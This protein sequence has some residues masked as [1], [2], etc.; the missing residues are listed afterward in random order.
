M[1][2]I[3]KNRESKAQISDLS[4]GIAGLLL[5]VSLA[6]APAPAW[7]AYAAGPAGTAE[8]QANKSGAKH[9]DDDYVIGPSDV[10]AINVWKDTELSRTVLVRPDGRISLPLIGE[11]EV[12]GLTA[13]KVQELIA[14]KLGPYISKPQV[15]VIVTEVKS[16]TYTVV[17]KIAHPGSFEFGKPTTILDAIAIAGGFLDFARTNK[18]YVIRRAEDGSQTRLPFDYKKVINGQK[19]DENIDLKNG[20]TV[21]VP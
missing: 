8:D 20:D 7:G 2:I 21:V 6:F 3:E 5:I 1:N 13:L 15:T 19:A 4:V 12:S 14:Q 9:V 10:L 11:L 16:R 18:I 17:G